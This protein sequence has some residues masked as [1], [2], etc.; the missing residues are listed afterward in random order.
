MKGIVKMTFA[1][2]SLSTRHSLLKPANMVIK[3]KKIGIKRNKPTRK[4]TSAPDPEDGRGSIKKIKKRKNAGT[5]QIKA[6][7]V[8]ANLNPRTSFLARFSISAFSGSEYA[9]NS[10]LPMNSINKK[11]RSGK[12]KRMNM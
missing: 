12:P 2:K 9:V 6:S 3:D 11:R 10:F 8:V 7:I 4:T 1:E 5:R